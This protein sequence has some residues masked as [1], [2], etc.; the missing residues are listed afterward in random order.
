MRGENTRVIAMASAVDAALDGWVPPDD[1]IDVAVAAAALTVLNT[2]MGEISDA[3]NCTAILATYGARATDPRARGMVAVLD[4]Q[5]PHDPDRTMEQLSRI[6]AAH[7][8]DRQSV[9]TARLMDGAL[10]RELLRPGACA[11]AGPGRVGPRA[12]MPTGRGSR[13]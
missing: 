7:G 8:F 4:A 2:L 1:R 11:G 10:P 3:P 9:A 6:D 5:D 12:R 13:R